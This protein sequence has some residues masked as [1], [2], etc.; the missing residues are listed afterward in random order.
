MVLIIL[1]VTKKHLNNCQIMKQTHL[2]RVVLTHWGRVT[3]ICVSN[4]TIIGS[5]R[6]LSPG[7]RQANIW[8]SAGILLIGP[9]GTK[10]SEILIGIQTLSF[11]KM[12]VKMSSAK[13]RQFCPGLSVLR[14][15]IFK[16]YIVSE[17]QRFVSEYLRTRKPY[18][19]HVLMMHVAVMDNFCKSCFMRITLSWCTWRQTDT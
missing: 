18:F 6:G 16:P 12:H 5:Y 2:L 7:R 9:L 15:I 10:F 11:T 4:L 1:Q 17:N 8:T 19:M 3:H 13:W 14:N